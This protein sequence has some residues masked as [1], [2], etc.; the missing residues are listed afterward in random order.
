MKASSLRPTGI[1]L[2]MELHSSAPVDL[3]ENKSLIGPKWFKLLCNQEESCQLVGKFRQEEK[4][5]IW[6]FIIFG[7]I[8][9]ERPQIDLVVACDTKKEIKKHL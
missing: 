4:R 6:Q 1:V 7:V 8:T 5:A 9:R 3:R 2:V